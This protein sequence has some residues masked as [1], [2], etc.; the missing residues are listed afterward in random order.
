[1]TATSK[2]T[3]GRMGTSAVLAL[4]SSFSK[5]TVA[6]ERADELLLTVQ[7]AEGGGSGLLLKISQRLHT[8][9]TALVYDERMCAHACPSGNHPDRPER[10]VE[11]YRELHRLG[12]PEHC[13]RVPSRLVQREEVLLVHERRHWDRIEWAVGQEVTGRPSNL[14]PVCLQVG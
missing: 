6:D 2:Q 4:P 5:L 1:M 13:T 11:L 10:I 12:F 7:T 3:A 14:G 8:E 9:Q